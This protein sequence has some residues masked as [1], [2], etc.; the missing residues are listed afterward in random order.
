MSFLAVGAALLWTFTILCSALCCV[1]RMKH[2]KTRCCQEPTWKRSSSTG[3]TQGLPLNCPSRTTKLLFE[4]TLEQE[5][6]A[7]WPQL[8]EDFKYLREHHCLFN[9]TETS[10][11]SC[12]TSLSWLRLFRV[13][14]LSTQLWHSCGGSAWCKLNK[15]L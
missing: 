9:L 2:V 5:M 4:M 14:M 15:L 6:S 10:A 3:W 1:I 13:F 11:T 8:V 12:A 7:A